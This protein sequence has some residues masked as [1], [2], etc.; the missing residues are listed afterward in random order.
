MEGWSGVERFF[1]KVHLIPHKVKATVSFKTQNSEHT[2]IVKYWT[3]CRIH[4]AFTEAVLGRCFICSFTSITFMKEALLLIQGSENESEHHCVES[5][6]NLCSFQK[7][8]VPQM[9]TVLWRTQHSGAVVQYQRLVYCCTR[10]VPELPLPGCAGS[11]FTRHKHFSSVHQVF[12]PFSLFTQELK[13]SR[14]CAPLGLLMLQVLASDCSLSFYTVLNCFTDHDTRS[15][16]SMVS[17]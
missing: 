15:G 16:S 1:Y 13:R 10:T 14:V 17:L 8:S 3:A 5:S 4:P 12:P 6:R 11:C 7:I 2:E 9:Q